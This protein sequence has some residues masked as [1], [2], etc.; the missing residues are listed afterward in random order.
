MNEGRFISVFQDLAAT[1]ECR[2]RVFSHYL[3]NKELLSMLSMLGWDGTS[4]MELDDG[5]CSHTLSGS[6]LT[7]GRASS[8]SRLRCQVE[9]SAG[10][11]MCSIEIRKWVRPISLHG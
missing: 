3:V 9:R 6:M 11:S 10:Q 8:S 5:Q 1:N 2:A 7:G 4:A